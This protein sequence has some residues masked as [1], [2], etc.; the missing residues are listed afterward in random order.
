MEQ[1]IR[2][3]ELIMVMGV[4]RSGTTALFHSLAT[5][6]T[7]TVLPE[8][9]DSAFYY[10]F[11]L[12]PVTE[13]APLIERIGGRILL[14]PISETFMRSLAEVAKEF[15]AYPVR[16][17][18]IYRDPVNV[19]HSM[20]REKWIAPQDIDR[21]DH[22][23]AWRQRNQYALEFQRQ[24]SD[25]IAVLRYEDLCLD[26]EVFG[27]LARWL[28]LNCKP[29]FRNDSAMGRKHVPRAAQRTIDA[30]SSRTLRALNAAR[31]FKPRLSFRFKRIV[32][33]LR[34]RPVG[35]GAIP[36][37]DRDGTEA[38]L[39]ISA[40]PE[41]ACLPSAVGGLHFWLNAA[42]ICHRNGLLSAPVMESGPQHMIASKVENGP[43]GLLSLNLR[44]TLY[45]PENKVEE[46]RRGASGTLIF[47]L[48]N[49]GNFL[50]NRSGFAVFALFRP[51]PPY[52]QERSTLVRVGP[53]SEA[54]PA[55]F[56]QWHRLVNA[57]SA[58]IISACGG[59]DVK[60]NII[61]TPR[62]S[63]PRQQWELIVVRY[64]GGGEEFS[65]SANGVLG[66]SI[67]LASDFAAKPSG[68]YV[69][70]L[71]GFTPEKES[72]FY[73]EVADLIIFD[74]VL[75]GDETSA[76]TRY[77]IATHGM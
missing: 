56:L 1:L 23:L 27:Q 71:G 43:Y 45:Y 65:I 35:R 11:R 20:Q 48:G 69:L 10:Q 9:I 31:T 49:D 17:V 63:H 66:N 2:P 38:Q 22:V 62:E 73:G 57:S 53:Q 4:Q 29:S 18:W 34:E 50:F 40:S 52:N 39:H 28:S 75:T 47:D 76:V 46:R 44:G 19:L 30:S 55:F 64:T 8:D 26:P 12:R 70:E 24:F 15:R 32:S 59:G 41:S 3:H 37:A 74:R 16:F 51:N 36:I 68:D 61:S 7:L 5:D 67:R 54:A 72:L 6:K 14:K 42:A 13:L 77:L 33:R 21:P 25:Q 60:S 58:A